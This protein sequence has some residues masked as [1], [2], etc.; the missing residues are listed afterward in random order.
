M[1]APGAAAVEHVEPRGETPAERVLSL[2][3]LGDLVSIYLSALLGVDPSP[4]EPIERLKELL[5]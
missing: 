1:I 2:V 4:M 3:L 5:R